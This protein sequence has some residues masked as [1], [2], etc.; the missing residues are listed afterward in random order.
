MLAS[1]ATLPL[2]G[3]GFV[4]GLKHALESDHILAVSTVVTE[5]RGVIHTSLVGTFWGIGHTVSL[6]S[7]AVLVL[8]FEVTLSVRFAV[9]AES[10]VAVMLIFLGVDLLRKVSIAGISTGSLRSAHASTRGV[11]KP[12]LIGLVHGLAGSAALMLIVVATMPSTLHGLVYVAVFGLG[13]IGGMCAMSVLMGIPLVLGGQRFEAF[14]ENI[15]IVAGL[16]SIGFGIVL[17]WAI[18][19]SAGFLP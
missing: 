1:T 5:N 11:R 16:L 10:L 13:T 2:L 12:F 4:L 9:L 8:A 7:V 3:L 15:K 17:A 14:G 18:S 6:L 19:Q